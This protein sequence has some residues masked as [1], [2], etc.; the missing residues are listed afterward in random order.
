MVCLA[1]EIKHGNWVCVQSG[2]Q[3]MVLVP[4][5]EGKEPFGPSCSRLGQDIIIL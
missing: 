5:G 4:P 3:S 1:G 2:L